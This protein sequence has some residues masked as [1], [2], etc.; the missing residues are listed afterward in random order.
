[1]HTDDRLHCQCTAG[2]G[3][4]GLGLTNLKPGLSAHLRAESARARRIAG[5]CGSSDRR[6]SD[7]T[8]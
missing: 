4:A 2:T 7:L 6:V 5:Y 1:M 3:A 8:L